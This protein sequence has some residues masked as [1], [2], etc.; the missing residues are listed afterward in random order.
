MLAANHSC[1]TSKR[2]QLECCQVG[3][4]ET[5]T[6]PACCAS[7]SPSGQVAGVGVPITVHIL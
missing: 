7:C 5:C 3:L 6:P 4:H 1:V 2:L